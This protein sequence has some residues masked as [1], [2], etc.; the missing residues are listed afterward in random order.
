MTTPVFKPPDGAADGVALTVL[1]GADVVAGRVA[2]RRLEPWTVTAAA[3]E[4]TWPTEVGAT[5]TELELEEVETEEVVVGAAVDVGVSDVVDGAADVVSGALLVVV[6]G[7][8]G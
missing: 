8:G 5:D 4:V 6:S 2:D 1:T 7:A 3:V